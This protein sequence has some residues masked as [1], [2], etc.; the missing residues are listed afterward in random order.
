MQ[1]VIEAARKAVKRDIEA[2]LQ[3]KDSVLDLLDADCIN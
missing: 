3:E 1:L 2:T